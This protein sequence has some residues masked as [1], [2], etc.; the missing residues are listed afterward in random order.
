MQQLVDALACRLRKKGVSIQLNTP[1]E[2]DGSATTVICTAACDAAGL[3]RGIAPEASQALS[4]IEMLPLVRI[5]AFYPGE[6]APLGGR[7]VLFPRGT[8][9]RALGAVFNTNIFPG[10]RGEYSESWI[11]GGASDRGVMDL[12]DEALGTAMDRDRQVLCGRGKPPA[13]RSVHRWQ[14]GLPHYDVQLESVLSQGLDLPKGIFL[15]G[16]YVG[17]IGVPML[18]EQ[19]SAVA[20]RVREM[21]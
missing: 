3:L 9:V 11:Y 18:L 19:A 21:A 20:A 5:T 15:V 6:E 14:A 16:N 2:L 12:S 13:A 4:T 17:G 8:G 7:G 10:R 1:A